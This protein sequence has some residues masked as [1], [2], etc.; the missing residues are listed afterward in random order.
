MQLGL[1][2]AQQVNSFL[3]M[4]HVPANQLGY[5]FCSVWLQERSPWWGLSKHCRL[6][7]L[8]LFLPWGSS[9]VGFQSSKLKQ[10]NIF[11][12]HLIASCGG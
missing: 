2:Q 9:F 7:R 8:D 3:R 11:L 4:R 12:W 1:S 10:V 5:F 6:G